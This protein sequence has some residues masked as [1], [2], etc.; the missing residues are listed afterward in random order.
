MKRVL[1][2]ILIAMV[3]VVLVASIVMSS[4]GRTMT[5]LSASTTTVTAGGSSYVLPN[6]SSYHKSNFHAINGLDYGM[7]AD[8]VSDN[9]A[10]FANAQDAAVTQN[11]PLYVPGSGSRYHF[12]TGDIAIRSGITIVGDKTTWNGSGFVGGTVFDGRLYVYNCVG[13]V[14]NGIS[15]KN[16]NGDG[17]VIFGTT[18]DLIIM[19]GKFSGTAH[20]LLIEQMGST[21]NNVRVIDCDTYGGIHGFV[22]KSKDVTFTRCVAHSATS[23]GFVFA[24]DNI[25][26][27]GYVSQCYH[28]V[29][30]ACAASGCSI[31]IAIYGRDDFSETNAN[32]IHAPQDIY[33]NNCDFSNNQYGIYIGDAGTPGAGI[34]F[35]SPAK[36]YIANT[37]ATGNSISDALISRSGIVSVVNCNIPNRSVLASKIFGNYSTGNDSNPGTQWQPVKTAQK[38]IDLIPDNGSFG[39]YSG[40]YTSGGKT[41]PS[42]NIVMTNRTWGGNKVFVRGTITPVVTGTIRTVSNT[43]ASSATANSRFTDGSKSWTSN[44]HQYRFVKVGTQNPRPIVFNNSSAI[45]VGTSFDSTPSA[46]TSYT[47]YALDFVLDGTGGQESAFEINNTSNITLSDVEAKN[48]GE[49]VYAYNGSSVDLYNTYFHDTAYAI[50]A[51]KSGIIN[52]AYSCYVNNPYACFIANGSR[53]RIVN[54][55]IISYSGVG[56][57]VSNLCTSALIRC[58]FLSAPVINNGSSLSLVGSRLTNTGSADLTFTNGAKGDSQTSWYVGTTSNGVTVGS[59][60]S[61]ITSSDTIK[62]HPNVGFYVYYNS[63]L[64]GL[65]SATFSN[66]GNNYFVYPFTN[67]YCDAGFPATVV[68]GNVT[69][70]NVITPTGLQ[71]VVTGANTINTINIPYT[72]WSG[73]ITMLPSGAFS[74]GLAGNIAI[75]STAVVGRALVMTYIPTTDKWYPSY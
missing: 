2:H 47:I 63:S 46:G 66:N 28:N 23:N 11:R 18:N 52:Q 57:L 35:L 19:N 32:N 26:G 12:G 15:I 8:G 73:S 7:K 71:F 24:S 30:D 70:D 67:S 33:V 38:M 56:F 55:N 14:L 21:T 72:G 27:I 31:G 43:W 53:S 40:I 17:G 1:Q 59:N 34:T 65:A 39:T 50:Y 64:A 5:R 45:E 41:L 3:L 25:L 49:C 62:N 9:T 69:S 58:G 42:Q 10:A 54:T 48:F 75:V 4:P 13:T 68:G 37:H 61:F 22:S 16:D 44:Q 29:L 36:I 74:T 60:S 6:I 20:C 51:D